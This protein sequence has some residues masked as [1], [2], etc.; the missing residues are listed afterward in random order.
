MSLSERTAVLITRPSPGAEETAARV[1]ALG[2]DPVLA[3]MLAIR[4]L[5][6][7]WLLPARLDA[8][9]LTSRNGLLGLPPS[10]Y[11]TPLF[12][13][14]AATAAAAR[15]HG[16]AL[17]R[18]ADADGAALRDLVRA[19]VPGKRPSLL[20][21]TARGQ[22]KKL[23]AGL[24]ADGFAVHRR[25]VYR[26]PARPVVAGPCP[27]RARGWAAC[28]AVL[29]GRDGARLCRGR[30]T[31]RSRRSHVRCRCV[32]YRR[33]GLRGIRGAALATR[34]RRL[35]PDPGRIAGIAEMS[36]EHPPVPPGTETIEADPVPV[37]APQAEPSE[38]P[39]RRRRQRPLV[40]W[41]Y[42]LAFVVLGWA[43]MF[44]WWHPT[45]TQVPPAEAERVA[46]LDQQVQALGTQVKQL[47]ARPAGQPQELSALRAQLA[48]LAARQPP[49]PD[50]SGLERRIGALEQRAPQEAAPPPDSGADPAEARGPRAAGR[51]PRAGEPDPPVVGVGP[52]GAGR[53]SGAGRA[54]GAEPAGAGPAGRVEPTD[55]GTSGDDES[56]DHG[57]VGPHRRVRRLARRHRP[58]RSE[59]GPAR[60]RAAGRLR[61]GAGARHCPEERRGRVGRPDRQQWCRHQGAARR[62][63]PA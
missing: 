22:G 48:T 60:A 21:P 26:G 62:G 8:V 53:P 34:P 7:D 36:E 24:R 47:A 11:A 9:L 2:L 44:L 49:A 14:G 13:A 42:A 10:L 51:F 58:A 28:R 25:A 41:V 3:P 57:T 33:A 4:M 23:A 59:A 20:L 29:L 31:R 37:E 12:A 38:P 56:A 6:G 52:G 50:L 32:R 35:P 63:R 45:G 54:G 46:A 39:P 19:S 17:V 15:A 43:V 30:P 55:A 5:P 40:P 61:Q 1:A 16:F 18:S 27:R